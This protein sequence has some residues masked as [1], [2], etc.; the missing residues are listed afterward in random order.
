VQNVDLIGGKRSSLPRRTFRHKAEVRKSRKSAVKRSQQ[1]K[2][3]RSS[4]LNP[5]KS[6]RHHQSLCDTF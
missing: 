6:W 1:I 5:A 4:K 2:E 3:V